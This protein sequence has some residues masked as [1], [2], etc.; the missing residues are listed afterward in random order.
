MCLWFSHVWED[1]SICL[2]EMVFLYFYFI[3]FF[4]CI[5]PLWLWSDSHSSHTF[6]LSQHGAEQMNWSFY[7]KLF[8]KILYPLCCLDWKS[9][10]ALK[11]MIGE[12]LLQAAELCQLF[13]RQDNPFKVSFRSNQAWWK[14]QSFHLFRGRLVRERCSGADHRGYWRNAATLCKN[15]KR[16]QLWRITTQ[17]DTVVAKHI[18]QRLDWLDK[19]VFVLNLQKYHYKWILLGV[20][21]KIRLMAVQLGCHWACAPETSADPVN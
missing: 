3:L 13:R 17:C 14:Q 10:S 18:S 16:D 21:H 19:V 8:Q 20:F 4:S 2:E 6:T 15:L 11:I 9:F 5:Y 12:N 7:G 1:Q